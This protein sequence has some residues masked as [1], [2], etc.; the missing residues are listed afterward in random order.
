MR[1]IGKPFYL[2]CQ[3]RLMDSTHIGKFL[4]KSIW[5]HSNK[6]SVE[7]RHFWPPPLSPWPGL[8][9]TF[10]SRDKFKILDPTPIPCTSF[11]NGPL[12]SGAIRFFIWGHKRNIANLKTILMEIPQ[13]RSEA[14]LHNYIKHILLGQ[15][16]QTYDNNT[17]INNSNFSFVLQPHNKSALSLFQ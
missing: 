10:P 9:M 4:V 11:M 3:L 2:P 17:D 6:K 15:W 5:D 8:F 13:F 16:L 12:S 1:N 7:N 14:P